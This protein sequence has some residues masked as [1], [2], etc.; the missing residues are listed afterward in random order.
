MSNNHQKGFFWQHMG[1]DAETARH[2][3]KE[4]RREGDREKGGRKEGG[5]EGGREELRYPVK[6]GEETL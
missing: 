2:A 3:E 5:K 4:E 1:V 6:K